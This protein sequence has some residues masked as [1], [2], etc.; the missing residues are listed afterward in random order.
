[1]TLATRIQTSALANDQSNIEYFSGP[2]V[3]RN[4]WPLDTGGSA[5]EMSGR[6]VARA[7]LVVFRLLNIFNPCSSIPL[8]DRVKLFLSTATRL[9]MAF[10]A[11]V[12]IAIACLVE[13]YDSVRNECIGK[14][15]FNL[16]TK[17]RGVEMMKNLYLL[18]NHLD[19]WEIS[20]DPD[21]QRACDHATEEFCVT[22]D[23]HFSR[24]FSRLLKYLPI[25]Y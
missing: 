11:I 2:R 16:E 24:E 19:R 14:N 1:M 20:K 15:E 21:A 13:L 5:L 9:S 23:K 18:E 6:G 4:G 25:N 3:K 22:R 17:N 10:L 12:Y 8:K 7:V